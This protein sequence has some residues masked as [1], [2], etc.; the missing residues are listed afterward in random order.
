MHDS[1]TAP[2]QAHDRIAESVGPCALSQG[3]SHIETHDLV[4]R[5][6][7]VASVREL[8]ASFHDVPREE[9]LKAMGISERTLQRAIAADRRLD[10]NASDRTLRL[11]AVTE[12]AAEVLGSREV[13]ERWLVTEAVGLDRRRP[14]DLLQSTEGTELVKTL[15]TRMDYGVYA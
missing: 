5:G 7:P 12:R 13:A 15:L 6:L 3:L 11:A 10:V 1:P 4:T 8:I 9:I 14:I 2:T